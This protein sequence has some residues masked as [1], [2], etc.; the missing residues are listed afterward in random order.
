MGTV[1]RATLDDADAIGDIA[2]AKR[3]QYAR[4]QPVFWRPHRDARASHVTY[5]RRQLA[6]DN[7]R[8][9]RFVHEEDGTVD[10]YGG[11]E[12][13]PIPP[14]FGAAGTACVVDGFAPRR[15]EQWPTAGAAVRDA[16]VAA[17]A[18]AGAALVAVVSGFDDEPK[19][20][21]LERAGLRPDSGWHVR[22]RDRA[23]A[24]SFDAGVRPAGPSDAPAI[25]DLAAAALADYQGY[26]PTF[27]QRA[28]DRRAEQVAALGAAV[29]DPGT[30]AVVHETAGRV[31]GCAVGTL[32]AAPAVYDPGGP[33]LLVGD[34]AVDGPDEKTAAALVEAVDRLGRERGAVL[35]AVVAGQ[36][37]AA[38]RRLL[39]ELGF[40]QAS[41]W[42][43][44]S[45]RGT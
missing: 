34:F 38:R 37:D 18:D 45:L 3:A 44:R 11:G 33:V 42:Y 25:L 8:V 22:E 10:A 31:E 21:V 17:A 26:Q 19:R 23:P 27:W 28:G 29:A 5:V 39:A 14:V 15:S 40:R 20:A 35:T 6:A 32:E 13:F 43:V 9:F 30:V 16:I 36:A 12:L 7:G 2:E 24:G 1:R 41:L 4:Y